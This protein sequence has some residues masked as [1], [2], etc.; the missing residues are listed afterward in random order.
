MSLVD[1]LISAARHELGDP[2]VYGAEGPSTFDCSGLMQYVFGQV[3]IKLPRTAAEQQDAA[4]K[5]SAPVPGDLVFWGDPATHV[6]LYIGSGKMIAA[7]HSGAVVQIQDVYGSPTY[8][9]VSGLGGAA[10]YLANTATLGAT[11][12][13]SNLLTKVPAQVRDGIVMIIFAG[14][15]LA[16]VG[17]GI[18]KLVSPKIM[19]KV[20]DTREMIPI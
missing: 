4:A 19:Q 13:A 8:G 14:T 15:G 9:R 2:Y 5:V 12:L 20:R 11:S 7:P 3:G 10:T 18:T 6:A 16:L 1:D 17:F